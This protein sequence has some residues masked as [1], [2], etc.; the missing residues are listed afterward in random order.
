MRAILLYRDFYKVAVS[1]AGFEL[2]TVIPP[3]Q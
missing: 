3:P 1:S 2:K